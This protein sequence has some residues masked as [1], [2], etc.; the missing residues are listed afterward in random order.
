M[1]ISS[2][3]LHTGKQGY[4]PTYTQPCAQGSQAILACDRGEGLSYA[5]G[6]KAYL[7][8]L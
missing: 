4:P 5:P 3:L 1:H 2:T 6:Q 8:D 7:S